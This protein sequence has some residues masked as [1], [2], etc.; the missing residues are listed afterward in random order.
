[1]YHILNKRLLRIELSLL[2][3]DQFINYKYKNITLSLLSATVFIFDIQN[4]IDLNERIRQW[5]FARDE[6][7]DNS[8]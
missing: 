4:I 3:L 6:R 2:S 7:Q 8:G 1:V 5:I